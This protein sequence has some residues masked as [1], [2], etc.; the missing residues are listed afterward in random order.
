[1][2]GDWQTNG[3]QGAIERL[4]S[5]NER[6]KGELRREHEIYLRNVAD[7]D[8]Y[9]RRI[10]RERADAALAGKREIVLSLLEILD[11]FEHA[12]V[13]LDRSPAA[14]SAGLQAIHRRLV[15]LLEAQGVTPFESVGH[16]FDPSL[17][18][19]VGSEESEQLEP[20]TVLDELSTGYRWGDDL[21]RPARVRVVR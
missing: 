18:E 7:F 14:V 10:E 19:A 5:E 2:A 9:R 12:L 3:D 13:H 11:D 8:N 1:M 4:R 21:L 17:H 20:G 15:R 16:P 6:L